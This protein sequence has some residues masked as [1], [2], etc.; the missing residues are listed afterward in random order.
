M[1]NSIE[2]QAPC[3]QQPRPLDVLLREL[4]EQAAAV[5]RY[6]LQGLETEATQALADYR[7]LFREVHGRLRQ[8][9]SR[10]FANL[11]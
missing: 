9:I 10:R 5:R 2:F 6:C 7:G 3:C 8:D 4:D 11:I 1:D